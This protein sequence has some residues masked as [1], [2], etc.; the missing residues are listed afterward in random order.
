MTKRTMI[1][2]CI[3]RCR[4]RLRFFLFHV[5][6]S[7]SPT[8][9]NTSS[10]CSFANRH[11]YL[12]PTYLL[13][14]CTHISTYLPTYLQH[15]SCS[16]IMLASLEETSYILHEEIIISRSV[17]I[18]GNSLVLPFIDCREAIRCFHIV[19]SQSVGVSFFPFSF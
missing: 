5:S 1:H 14:M 19:V 15:T 8:W 13:P 18:Q 7:L 9:Y 6:S 16:I 4:L 2:A 3:H 12:S 11:T 17:T 10:I